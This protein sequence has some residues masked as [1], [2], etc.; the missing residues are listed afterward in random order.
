MSVAVDCRWCSDSRRVSGEICVACI[1][2]NPEPNA[3]A[4]YATQADRRFRERRERRTLFYC[5]RGRDRPFQAECRCV[6]QNLFCSTTKWSKSLISLRNPVSA[7]PKP[8]DLGRPRG[9]WGNP[10]ASAGY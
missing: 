1:D 10:A 5:A 7:S 8:L 4:I 2:R 9:P 3:R 6:E